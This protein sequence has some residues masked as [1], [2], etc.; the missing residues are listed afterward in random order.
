METALDRILQGMYKAQ[1]ITYIAAHPEAF[2]ELLTMAVSDS[3]PY[4]WRAAWLL[5]SC[6]DDNDPR[7]NRQLETVINSLS[8]KTDNHQRELLKILLQME[9]SDDHDA[10]LYDFC[11]DTWKDS[12]KQPSVRHNAIKMIVKIGKKYPELLDEIEYFT[13]DGY[14]ASL[15][16]AVRNS[17][18][19]MMV[20]LRKAVM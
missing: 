2:N 3:H 4:R 19:K 12:H 1:M 10:L 5:W 18:S 9:L 17:V 13:Q 14:L 15:S 11:L 7:V 16:P 8:G 6:M 20:Q